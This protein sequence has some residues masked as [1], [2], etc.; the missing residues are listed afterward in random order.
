VVRNEREL[1]AI[2]EYIQANPTQWD[3]DENNPRNAMP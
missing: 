3:D 1:T 2:R